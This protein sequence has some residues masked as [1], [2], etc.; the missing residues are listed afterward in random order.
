MK[1]LGDAVGDQSKAFGSMPTETAKGFYQAI[2][3]GASSVEQATEAMTAAN[4]LAIGG[5][6]DIE[7]AVDGLTSSMNAY[8]GEA[9]S[10]TD[11]SDSMFTA[12]KAGKTTI[13]E[14]ANSIG[15]VAPLAAQALKRQR[16]QQ[17]SASNSI[18]RL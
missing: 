2:S 1:A 16:W 9:G 5:V 10:F 8:G 4:K 18:Q 15:A 3:A 14:L 7:T 17:N 13:G 6:T 11:I 12:V